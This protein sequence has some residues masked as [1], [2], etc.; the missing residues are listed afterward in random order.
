MHFKASYLAASVCVYVCVRFLFVCMARVPV[1][2]FGLPVIVHHGPF[3]P[4]Q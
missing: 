4:T 3:G 2:A 1:H